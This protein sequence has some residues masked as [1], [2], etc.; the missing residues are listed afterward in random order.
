MQKKK[1]FY[2]F[3]LYI[4]KNL[5]FFFFLNNALYIKRGQK[6]GHALTDVFGLRVKLQILNKGFFFFF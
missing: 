3:S 6:L 5:F 1:E 2:F 4:V